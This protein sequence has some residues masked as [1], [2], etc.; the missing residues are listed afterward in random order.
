MRR[1]MARSLWPSMSGVL[2]RMFHTRSSIEVAGR[3]DGTGGAG[4][5][6]SPRKP[7]GLRKVRIKAK[8]TMILKA[9]HSVLKVDFTEER[10]EDVDCA[11]SSESRWRAES[12][13]VISELPLILVKPSPKI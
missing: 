12:T 6:C 3:L 9:E 2:S 13:Y 7:P 10:L 1:K 11:S 8:N 5:G 4:V